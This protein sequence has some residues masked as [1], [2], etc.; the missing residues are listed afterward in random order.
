MY[1]HAHEI[2]PLLPVPYC[3]FEIRHVTKVS[4]FSY[5]KTLIYSLKLIC[6]GDG[7]LDEE[8]FEYTLNDTFDIPQKDCRAA[9]RMI[10]QVRCLIWFDFYA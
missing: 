1:L 8:E 4:L 6:E 10:S 5:V 9:F 2:K 3:C 7:V